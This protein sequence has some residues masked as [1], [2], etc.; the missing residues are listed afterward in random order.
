METHP[1]SFKCSCSNI[2]VKS[3]FSL[4]LFLFGQNL[5]QISQRCTSNPQSSYPLFW[6]FSISCIWISPV[7]CIWDVS[8]FCTWDHPIYIYISYISNIRPLLFVC[9]HILLFFLFFC[10]L[11]LGLFWSCAAAPVLIHTMPFKH[12]SV[13]ATFETIGPFKWCQKL[14]FYLFL[15]A[16][17]SG[18]KKVSTVPFSCVDIS[19]C[20]SV[21]VYG[22]F[23]RHF[24]VF[25]NAF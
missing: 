8:K 6:D 2:W 25:T 3:L 16:F 5:I 7:F 1:Q 12:K 20:V 21:I 19:F 15:S 13:S 18:A 11:Y 17:W 14:C 4:A 24:F 10:V 9:W 22:W 23:I